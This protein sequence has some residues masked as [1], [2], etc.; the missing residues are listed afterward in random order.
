MDAA[1]GPADAGEDGITDGWG[2][3]EV[4]VRFS[5]TDLS[6]GPVT[7]GRLNLLMAGV[8]WYL[9]PHVR[10]MFNSGLGRASGGSSAGDMFIFQTR[11]GIDF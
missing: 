4:A 2:A 10:W 1:V 8:N 6:D 5:Y 3:V 9:Q 11:I 7:G